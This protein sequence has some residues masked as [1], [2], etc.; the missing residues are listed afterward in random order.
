MDGRI[1]AQLNSLS[2]NPRAFLSNP[3]KSLALHPARIYSSGLMGWERAAPL[4]YCFPRVQIISWIGVL[5]NG[6]L[7]LGWITTGPGVVPS[8]EV[9][10]TGGIWGW[11]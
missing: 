4:I 7:E 9:S 11:G 10:G 1:A 8:D 6:L 3:A 2:V 5:L